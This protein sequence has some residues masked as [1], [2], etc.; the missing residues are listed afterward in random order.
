MAAASGP[1][2]GGNGGGGNGGSGLGA[3]IGVHGK[4]CHCEHLDHLNGEVDKLK[5]E[6]VNANN[7]ISDFQAQMFVIKDDLKGD[8]LRFTKLANIVQKHEEA[9]AQMAGDGWKATIASGHIPQVPSS[10]PGAN[11]KNSYGPN[12]PPA[13]LINPGGIP[14]AG[15]FRVSPP[16]Q[17]VLRL[18]I[19]GMIIWVEAD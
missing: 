6:V 8:G 10:M 11:D 13:A 17:T 16:A 12:G 19:I 4:P 7:H 5:T 15:F 3:R 14:G 18:M 2:D 1:S 9:H